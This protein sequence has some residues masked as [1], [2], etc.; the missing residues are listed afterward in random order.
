MSL[1]RVLKSLLFSGLAEFAL[2]NYYNSA[3]VTAQIGFKIPKNVTDENSFIILLDPSQVDTMN[4]STLSKIPENRYYFFRQVENE[5]IV[6]DDDP[7]GYFEGIMWPFP[8]PGIGV[9]SICIFDG[10][11]C[12]DCT[13]HSVCDHFSDLGCTNITINDAGF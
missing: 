4:S 13:K 2:E 9:W 7:A 12:Q 1:L 8:I 5:M 10:H 11:V 6:E 3:Q